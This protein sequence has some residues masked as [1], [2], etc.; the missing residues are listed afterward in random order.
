MIFAGGLHLGNLILAHSR[1]LSRSGFHL[2]AEFLTQNL[3]VGFNALHQSY[4][5]L[6]GEH[7]LQF[8]DVHLAADKFCHMQQ[9]VFGILVLHGDD[10]FLQR[11]T[12]VLL[13]AFAQAQ[14][15]RGRLLCQ[16]HLTLKGLVDGISVGYRPLAQVHALFALLAGST[17]QVTIEAVGVERSIGR[18][19]LGYGLEAC[20]ERQVRRLF[21][22]IHL[23]APE[24]LAVQANV[25]VTE[26]ILHKIRDESACLRRLVSLVVSSHLLYQAVQLRQ[27]PFI[28]LLIFRLNRIL[29]IPSI[30]IGI[31]GEEAIRIIQRS[32]ELTADLIHAFGVELQILPRTRVGQHIPAHGVGAILRQRAKRINRVTQAFRHL[33][34]LLIQHQTI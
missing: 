17:R 11:L 32:E 19:Q 16:G 10:G 5:A 24:T 6:F 4:L 28:Y 2:S 14:N 29:R 23:A 26:V 3:K 31:K 21:V 30:H 1:D 13:G 8:L 18:H 34:T 15:H 22:G 7:N 12:D 20:I 27:H 25:P 33:S 9:G